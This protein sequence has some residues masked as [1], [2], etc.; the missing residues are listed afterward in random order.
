MTAKTRLDHMRRELLPWRLEDP[1]LT[2]CGLR[3]DECSALSRKDMVAKVDREGQ[4]RAALS[5]CMTCWSTAKINQREAGMSGLLFTV[6]R[7]LNRVA[8]KD[9][10]ERKLVVYEFKAMIALVA[11]HRDEFDQMIRDLEEVVP[12][13]QARRV[14]A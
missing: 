8:W 9:G 7:E 14:R 13:S 1:G 3:A 11:N 10:D 6:Q 12:I 5:S 4:Q 2:E